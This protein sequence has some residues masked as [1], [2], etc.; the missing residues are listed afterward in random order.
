MGEHSHTGRVT[1]PNSRATEAPVLGT[2]PDLALCISSS[3]CSSVAFVISFNKL[4]N[5]RVSLNSLRH[6]NKLTKPE[7]GVVGTSDL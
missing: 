7:E 2:L 5:V 4:V 6:S 1:H 3:G